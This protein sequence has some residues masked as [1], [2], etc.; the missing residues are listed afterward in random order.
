MFFDIADDHYNRADDHES[1]FGICILEQ[2]FDPGFKPTTVCLSARNI[3]CGV[4]AVVRNL[5]SC[6]TLDRKPA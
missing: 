4:D 6:G 2:D 1:F 5:I 3:D